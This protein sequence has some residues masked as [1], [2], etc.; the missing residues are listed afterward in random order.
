MVVGQLE[1]GYS[2]ASKVA[3]SQPGWAQQK[4]E[5][6][7]PGRQYMHAPESQP[8]QAAAALGSSSE[9][10]A[11]GGSPCP[12]PSSQREPRQLE[13]QSGGLLLAVRP[14]TTAGS[15]CCC[16]CCCGCCWTCWRGL[17][18]RRGDA[19]C[20]DAAAAVI[21]AR[22]LP[23]RQRWI[24]RRRLQAAEGTPGRRRHEANKLSQ[25]GFVVGPWGPSQA[26]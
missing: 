14:P 13:C 11:A 3:D 6:E 23:R 5:R 15:A 4:F 21:N 18:A 9:G 2:L 22:T 24:G 17:G 16:C 19:S 10:P 8:A 1:L 26:G 20:R 7:P 25:R 12:R